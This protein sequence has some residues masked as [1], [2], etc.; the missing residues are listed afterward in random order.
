MD[1]DIQVLPQED[2]IIWQQVEGI[3]L[4]S[5]AV[6][7]FESATE[8]KK[9]TYKYLEYYKI[10]YPELFI[11]ASLQNK[12]IGYICASSDTISDD[13]LFKSQPHLESF[14]KYYHDFPAHLHI[15]CHR[16]ARGLGIG[17]LLVKALESVLSK[18]S[19]KGLH[20]ITTEESRNVSFYQKHNY[21]RVFKAAYNGANLILMGKPLSTS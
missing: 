12:V 18:K 8:K 1:V 20:L 13:E 14:I 7:S 19:I 16:E 11:V 6:Q 2:D 21:N 10:R 3:F 17:S 15:N 5:S 4:E 9:F